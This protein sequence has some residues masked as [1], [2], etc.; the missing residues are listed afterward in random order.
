MISVPRTPMDAWV[1]AKIGVPDDGDL[2][3]DALG[4]YQFEKLQATLDYVQQRSPF[5]RH[6]FSGHAN[7][8]LRGLED[9]ARWPLTAADDLCKDP[10]AFLCVSQSLVE[11]VVTLP[12]GGA[13]GHAKRLF[14]SS[15][16]LALAVDF[17]RHG[18]ST[19][20]D[21]WQRMLVMMPWERPNSV[22]RLLARGLDRLG[23]HAILHGPMLS[24]EA[25]LEAM[26][27]H[28]ADCLVG[29]PTQMA[30]LAQHAGATR[31]PA[32]QIKSVWLG[33]QNNQRTAVDEIG[34]FWNCP[35]YQHYGVA[36]MCPGGG[37]QCAARDGFHLR[38]ADLLTEIVDART[39]RPVPDGTFGEVAVTTL[40][41]EAMPLVR[42]RTGLRA[43]VMTDD[44]P[45]GSALRRLRL[46]QG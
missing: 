1:K 22:G 45:C 16:D 5:Y 27:H 7:A 3:A 23:A 17:F 36:E 2:S 29:I 11:R 31:I 44:C 40:T 12:S 43:A 33:T 13:D 34:R 38:E 6:H 37:V 21:S 28:H 35:V 30:A 41:R 15:A 24:A 42:Y 9:L 26:L 25:A 19:A 39:G 20:I 18:F 46:R 8:S 14:F 10:L 4:R 32:G